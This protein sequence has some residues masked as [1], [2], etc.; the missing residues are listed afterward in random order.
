MKVPL[1][2][3]AG[4][5]QEVDVNDD[6]TI[7]DVKECLKEEYDLSSLK[8]RFKDEVTA[9]DTKVKGLDFTPSDRLV[10][11]G[12]KVK[13]AKAAEAMS[14][15]MRQEAMEEERRKKKTEDKNTDGAAEGSKGNQ[16]TS[17]THKTNTGETTALPTASSLP[18]EEGTESSVGKDSLEPSG[19]GHKPHVIVKHRAGLDENNDLIKFVMEMGF[20]D[21]EQV[22]RALKAAYMDVDRAI[23]YLCSG[24]PPCAERALRET[25]EDEEI[26]KMSSWGDMG[27]LARAD[28]SPI[29]AALYSLPNF[30]EIQQIYTEN[31]EAF[32]LILEQL[33]AHY[34]ELFELIMENMDECQRIMNEVDSPSDVR[35]PDS[36]PVGTPHGGDREI[37]V[38]SNENCD[39]HFPSEAATSRMESPVREE[40]ALT[41]ED[42]QAVMELTDLGGGQWDQSSSMVVYLACEKNKEIAGSILIE[43]SGVPP[44]L[45]EQLF[46]R[47]RAYQFDG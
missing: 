9:D 5:V 28:D 3:L 34:P 10:I 21:R 42:V 35:S 39:T 24:I 1:K 47:N 40:V 37:S 25:L 31:P 2:T 44:E 19:R 33:R 11:I 18:L 13:I 38:R 14:Y 20:H 32:P 16:S 26:M 30:R 27:N 22:V 15:A 4:K 23:E 36:A 8:L 12:R 43:Y 46:Q 7:R 17:S 45:L 6:A 29:R 41:A